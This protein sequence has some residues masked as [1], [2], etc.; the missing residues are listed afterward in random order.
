M[1]SIAH[2]IALA[3]AGMCGAIQRANGYATDAGLRVYPGRQAVFSAEDLIDGPLIVI[4]PAEEFEQPIDAAPQKLRHS[5]AHTVTAA[6]LLDGADALAS[7]HDLLADLKRALLR[8]DV[9]RPVEAGQ[10]LGEAITYAGA[11]VELPQP[12]EQVLSVTVTLTVGYS[13]RRGDPTTT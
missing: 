13:E 1:S 2:R 12:G 10:V 4:A 6:A 3:L 11:T 9:P 7:A 8:V 5:V